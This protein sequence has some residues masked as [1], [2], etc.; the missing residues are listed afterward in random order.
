[1]AV[2]LIPTTPGEPFHSSKVR[3]E[4][5]DF[6]FRLA[7]NQREER[8]YLSILDESGGNLAMGIKLVCDVELLRSRRAAQPTLP[9]G[10]LAVIDLTGDNSPPLL[11]ELGIGKRC[12]L[13]YVETGT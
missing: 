11:D 4:G 8:W 1:M 12:E 9:P 10:Q 7:W 3:L 6:V 13:T 5:R 2:L